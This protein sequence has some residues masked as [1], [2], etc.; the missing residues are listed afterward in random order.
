MFNVLDAYRL[1]TLLSITRRSSRLSSN[2]GCPRDGLKEEVSYVRKSGQ[3]NLPHA[4]DVRD[5]V[6]S[7]ETTNYTKLLGIAKR[8]EN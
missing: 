7:S 5:H 3:A 8:I 6:D 4:V 1:R 2:C